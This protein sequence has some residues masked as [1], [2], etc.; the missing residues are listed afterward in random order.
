ESDAR[1]KGND[2]HFPP[3]PFF[4]TGAGAFGDSPRRP[5]F[6]LPRTPFVAGAEEGLPGYEVS[7]D[8]FVLAARDHEACSRAVK[9]ARQSRGKIGVLAPLA[10][11]IFFWRESGLR[12]FVAARTQTQAERLAQLLRHQGVTHDLRL[13]PFD[14]EWLFERAGEKFAS[15]VVGA[16]TR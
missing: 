13:G 15:I 16:L 14:P 8:P 11:R 3:G 2:P 5:S 12:V 6:P 1:Q 4:F 9:S 10:R 7:K